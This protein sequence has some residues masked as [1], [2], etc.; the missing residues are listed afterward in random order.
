MAI[1]IAGR[2]TATTV[3][4][5]PPKGETP[6]T[7]RLFLLQIANP[8]DVVAFT[9]KKKDVPL[10]AGAAAPASPLLARPR[11]VQLYVMG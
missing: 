1:H 6:T 9:K 4:T 2:D 11:E 5:D 7:T 10:R 3:R 8:S